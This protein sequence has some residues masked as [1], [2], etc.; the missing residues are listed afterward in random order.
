MTIR[1]LLL[2][3]MGVLLLSW[4]MGVAIYFLV[5]ENKKLKKGDFI[6]QVECEK[7]GTIYNA[8]CNQVVGVGMS[9]QRSVSKTKVDGPVLSNTPNYHYYSKK[10]QCPHCQKKEFGQ[11]LNINEY[12]N[13]TKSIVMKDGVRAFILMGVGG[14]MIL[15]LMKIPFG[16]EQRIRLKRVQEMRQEQLRTIEERTYHGL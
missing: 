1:I 12:Q 7:C 10:V 16:I 6:F 8:T 2:I 5:T 15:C 11:I 13:N 14:F 3:L 9:K 4:I